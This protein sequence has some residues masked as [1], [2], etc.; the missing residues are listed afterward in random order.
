M[1]ACMHTKVQPR[2]TTWPIHLNSYIMEAHVRPACTQR[3]SQEG[4]P[5]HR[6]ELA[7]LLIDTF[8]SGKRPGRPQTDE[9]AQHIRLNR[10]LDHYPRQMDKHKR[11]VV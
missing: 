7:M 5:G 3:F 1:L 6:L 9:H 2:G 4:L 11:C 10:D 8:C